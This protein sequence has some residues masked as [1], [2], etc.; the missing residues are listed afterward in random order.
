MTPQPRDESQALNTRAVVALVIAMGL[1]GVSFGASAPLVAS[2]LEERGFSEY[3]TGA[4]SA[5]LS[6]AIALLSPFAGTLV[7]RLGPR[8]ITLT[9]IILQGLC[10]SAL[11]LALAWHEHLLFPVRF[12][13][14]LAAA[15][16][17]IAAETAL[18]RGVQ[19]YQR[20]RAMA[21][22]GTVLGL[23]Y[24]GG[25]LLSAPAYAWFGLWCFALVGLL[26]VIV[27][28]VCRWGLKSLPRPKPETDSSRRRGRHLR[29]RLV[30]LGLFGAVIFGVLDNGMT[31]IYPVEGHRL[32]FDRSQTLNIVGVML[33]ASVLAQPLCGVLADRIGALRVL[34]GLGLIGLAGAITTGWLAW[35]GAGYGPNLLG[36]AIV[37]LAGGG[38]YPV[39]LK[40]IGDRVRSEALPK[41]NAAFSA[42]YGWASLF[43]PIAGALMIDIAMRTGL[44]GWALP[45]LAMMVFAIL[46]P[47]LALDRHWRR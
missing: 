17:F 24:G 10:F 31:G 2:I 26:A 38:T 5:T 11:G 25:V 14:G 18:L 22:Y 46:L 47:M 12:L 40:L 15:F 45:G 9:G 4:V 34:A 13:L 1:V 37:G 21:A 36:F 20:G 23:G 41:A 32:G 43:G 3:Y 6:L 16:T 27:A 29:W 28:P 19:P 33:I 7:A 42:A 8:W 30:I 44:L 35:S 39:C